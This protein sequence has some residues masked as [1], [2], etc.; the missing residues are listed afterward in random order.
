M[1]RNY[2]NKMQSELASYKSEIEALKGLR[3]SEFNHTN[4]ETELNE[5]IREKDHQLEKCRQEIQK[6]NNE[7][8][9]YRT[10]IQ[11][12]DEQVQRRAE[13]QSSENERLI[14][15]YEEKFKVYEFT[16]KELRQ[17]I[18]KR[19][20][21]L[22]QHMT[23]IDAIKEENSILE[24]QLEDIR[25]LNTEIANENQDLRRQVTKL[26]T[27]KNETEGRLQTISYEM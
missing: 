19:T 6:M 26:E 16:E 5:I 23:Q 11:E 13:L 21:E 20:K 3:E 22:N 18:E 24:K 7:L 15:E 12:K 9:Q 25:Y 1:L 2:N 17:E 8:K 14:S 10:T 4:I 27:E